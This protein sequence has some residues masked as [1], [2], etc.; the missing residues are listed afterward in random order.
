MTARDGRTTS[1]TTSRKKRFDPF[2]PWLQ[3]VAAVAGVIGTVVAV[4]SLFN[5]FTRP[6][7][8]A[9]AA[10]SASA[11]A[12]QVTIA[13][14]TLGET[15]VRG[16]GVF[17]GLV[18]DREV[19][20]FIGQPTAGNADWLPVIAELLPTSVGPDGTQSG[21]WEAVRP[22]GTGPHTWYAVI[23]PRASGAGNPYADLRE[24]GP[25]SELVKAVSE[26]FTTGE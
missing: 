4:I 20:L 11:V 18:P 6:A 3:G 12:A 19:V 22:A 17:Q 24:N 1:R 8:E 2:P 26:P 23:G 25:E 7:A 16:S 13:A 15:E 5:A 10:P 14:V 21:D 9:S